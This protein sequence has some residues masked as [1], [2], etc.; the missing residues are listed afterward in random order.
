MRNKK[1]CGALPKFGNKPTKVLRLNYVFPL[2]NFEDNEKKAKELIIQLQK[3]AL[4][5]CADESLKSKDYGS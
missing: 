4:Q 3:E 5:K 1:K 2:D